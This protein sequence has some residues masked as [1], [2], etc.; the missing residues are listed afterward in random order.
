MS[1]DT[2][3][4]KFLK[5]LPDDEV[6]V[7]RLRVLQNETQE[8]V[9]K[10]VD[11]TR[12]R[13]GQLEEQAR[14]KVEMIIADPARRFFVSLTPGRKN[15]LYELFFNEKYTGKSF[16]SDC[17]RSCFGFKSPPALFF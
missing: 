7:Y 2:G 5:W 6:K 3:W 8:S 12:A 10:M 1:F 14:A 15:L 9:A 4:M 13:V 11:R 16:E 17:P